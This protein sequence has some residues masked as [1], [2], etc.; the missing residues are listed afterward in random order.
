V[1]YTYVFSVLVRVKLLSCE[2]S[3]YFYI[4]M[5][6]GTLLV[7]RGAG[8]QQTKERHYPKHRLLFEKLGRDQ[9]VR[10]AEWKLS[11]IEPLSNRN[12]PVGCSC[13]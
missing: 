13:M 10:Y 2:W 3:R 11:K 1:Y 4:H 9:W 7:W 6:K 5:F 12:R 8:A